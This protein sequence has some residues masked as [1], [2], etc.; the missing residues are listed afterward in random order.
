MI[1][2]FFYGLPAFRITSICTINLWNHKHISTKHI[3]YTTSA[4][5]TTGV[6]KRKT[7][8][9]LL[10]SGSIHALKGF[11]PVNVNHCQKTFLL[12]SKSWARCYKTVL[13]TPC[14]NSML[15][16]RFHIAL[17]HT[18]VTKCCKYIL[19]T[20]YDHREKGFSAEHDI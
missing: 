18:E 6:Q 2:A 17:I 15:K 12:A 9:K 20:F 5:R 7:I 16:P 11:G 8:I 10:L 19:K 1:Q 14:S 3:Y 4:V 13:S